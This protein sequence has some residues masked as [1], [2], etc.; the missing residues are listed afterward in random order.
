MIPVSESYDFIPLLSSLDFFQ[1]KIYKS[2]FEIGN[3]LLDKELD[4]S[5]IV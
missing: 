1:F 3:L 5:F 2:S 4:G